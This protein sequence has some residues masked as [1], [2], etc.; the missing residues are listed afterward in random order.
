ME[1]D[2]EQNENEYLQKLMTA[3]FKVQG[4]EISKLLYSAK[5]KW[6]VGGGSSKSI[7]SRR[8]NHNVNIYLTQLIRRILDYRKFF[9]LD[10]ICPILH[11]IFV[12]LSSI[13]GRPT[14]A[15]I[16]RYLSKQYDEREVSLKRLSG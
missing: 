14:S 8:H 15:L 7:S 12:E 5:P 10:P 16:S 2:V 11:P 9:N 4:K 6:I 1:G 13:M 3:L